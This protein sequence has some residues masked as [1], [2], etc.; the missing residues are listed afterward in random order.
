MEAARQSS[1]LIRACD[2]TSFVTCRLQA[3]PS[4]ELCFSSCRVQLLTLTRPNVVVPRSEDAAADLTFV[5]GK[6]AR[7]HGNQVD[8]GS[9]TGECQW[10]HGDRPDA[11]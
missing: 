7:Q 4:L 6:V 9:A 11:D 5:C 1:K 2:V 3:A 8:R 10:T